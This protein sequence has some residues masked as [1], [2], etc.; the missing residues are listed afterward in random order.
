MQN[1]KKP[2][3]TDLDWLLNYF[4]NR[5]L[6]KQRLLDQVYPDVTELTFFKTLEVD[7][8]YNLIHCFFCVTQE[9]FHSE[10]SNLT[11]RVNEILFIKEGEIDFVLFDRTPREASYYSFKAGAI[12]GFEGSVYQFEPS[13]LTSL[14]NRTTLFSEIDTKFILEGE[15]PL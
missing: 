13:Q 8:K 11:T 4:Q 1:R 14:L 9:V 2:K 6:L 3:K 5:P 7:A 15:A 10:G 12:T